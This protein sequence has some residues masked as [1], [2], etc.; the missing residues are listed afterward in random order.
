MTNREK[1]MKQHKDRMLDVASTIT[2]LMHRVNKYTDGITIRYDEPTEETISTYGDWFRR[3]HHILPG[4]E[5]FMIYEKQNDGQPDYLLYVVNVTGDS[6]LTA[7]DELM[8]K[9][10]AKF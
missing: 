3:Y 4:D 7:A 10:A 8:R 2:E 5:Y 6:S 1:L 9:V